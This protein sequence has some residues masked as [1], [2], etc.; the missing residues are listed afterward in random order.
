MN[1]E[2]TVEI[3]SK[4]IEEIENILTGLKKSSLPEEIELDLAISKLKN[5]KENF[6]ILGRS[7]QQK[8]EQI[9]PE[10][11][12]KNPRAKQEDEVEEITRKTSVSGNKNIPVE[13][14]EPPVSHE[15]KPVVTETKGKKVF[16]SD[17]FQTQHTYRNEN[18]RKTHPKKN[19]SSKLKDRP[20][21]D[22]RRSIGLN[23][24]FMF[25]RDL[26]HG[27][28]AGYDQA[29]QFINTAS[30]RKK[31][32]EFVTQFNWNKKHEA[33]QQFM[34]LVQRKLK[35]LPDE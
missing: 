7:L 26:F 35:N 15:K 5:L 33:T 11:Q 32:E 27:D 31:V 34:D 17:T 16:L 28:S 13:K 4:D 6:L 22:L 1:F 29:I 23:E 25:I 18:I 2:R 10:K 9:I 20:I 21:T 30:S 8:P 14:T 12:N 24:K 19:L 3:L